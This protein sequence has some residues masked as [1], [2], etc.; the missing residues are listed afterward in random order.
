MNTKAINKI[1]KLFVADHPLFVSWSG[2]KDSSVVLDLALQAALDAKN[3]DN[4]RPKMFITHADTK[5]EN[6]EVALF[7]KK[8]ISKIES[9]CFHNGLDG[10]SVHVCEPS[11]A[12]SWVVRVI[13]GRT[14]PVFANKTTRECS[15]DFKKKPQDKMRKKLLRELIG[16][17]LGSPITLVG[18]RFEES[19]SRKARMEGRGESSSNV[20]V[21]P[22]GIAMFSPIADWTTVDVWHY[23]QT[24]NG[25]SN[26]YSD[27]VGLT[28]LYKAGSPKVDRVGGV[29]IPSARFGCSLCTVGEDK[30]MAA[31]LKN[32]PDK[33]GYM[34][35]LHRLQKFLRMT[36]HDFSRRTILGRS[37]DRHPGY[38]KISPDV[39]D[40]AMLEEILRYALTIDA[41]EQEAASL[42]GI[43]P[44]FQLVGFAELIAID[45]MWSLRGLFKPYHA[46]K[47]MQDVYSGG[48]RYEIPRM[49]QIQPQKA[50]TRYLPVGDAWTAD[51]YALAGLRDPFQEF[52]YQEGSC[53][54][55]GKTKITRSGEEILDVHTEIEL[56]VH[57]DEAGMILGY[58]V[59]YWIE[60]YHNDESPRTTAFRNYLSMGII[61]VSKTQTTKIDKMLK[62]TQYKEDREILP[63]MVHYQ[64]LFSMG[65]SKMEMEQGQTKTNT[66]M[67]GWR[68]LLDHT[69]TPLLRAM[70]QG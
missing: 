5:I 70:A 9:F 51:D 53:A 65:I 63:G 22:D 59:P 67:E 41:E 26:S 28:E 47:I 61:S 30:S 69:D 52:W 21:G 68:S 15:I 25:A 14:L 19:A 24:R 16:K 35:S 38:L 17:N 34:A 40:A 50:R 55:F 58:E 29:D 66:E 56:T 33:Y 20:W 39:Y 3:K 10:V 44:R 6:P 49:A 62:A 23:L 54:G 48:M 1:R 64:E 12:S 4:A 13:G 11:L 27:F 60:N 43:D 18:T 32:D 7:C 45:A 37:T 36:Q 42:L 2:G 31:M 57:D 46:L 8:E